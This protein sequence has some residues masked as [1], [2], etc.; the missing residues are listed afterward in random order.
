[1]KQKKKTIKNNIKAALFLLFFTL[2]ITYII[3]KDDGT[4]YNIVILFLS[5]IISEYSL[6][7]L[8]LFSKYPFSLNSIVYLFFLFFLGIAPA[9]QFKQNLVFWGALNRLSPEDYISGNIL[10]IFILLCYGICYHFFIGRSNL[11]IKNRKKSIT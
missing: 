2:F 3:F 9:L 1:M 7:V 4:Q 8:F 6:I 11:K 10:V 5:F